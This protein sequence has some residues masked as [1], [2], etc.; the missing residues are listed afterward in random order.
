MDQRS[1]KISL[2]GLVS[3]SESTELPLK[4]PSLSSNMPDKKNTNSNSTIK[5]TT[6]ANSQIASITAAPTGRTHTSSQTIDYKHIHKMAERK[7]RK[8]MRVVFDHLN[9]KLMPSSSHRSKWDIL[10]DAEK[11]MKELLFIQH[12]LALER[13]A[14]KQDIESLGN[15]K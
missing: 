2:Q 10:V 3:N 5:G 11:S 8:E 6:I 4:L 1:K 7:R 13:D 14:L 9:D 12:A 15:K